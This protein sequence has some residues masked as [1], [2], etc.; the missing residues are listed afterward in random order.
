[1]LYN[2]EFPVIDSSIENLKKNSSYD[3]LKKYMNRIMMGVERGT[4]RQP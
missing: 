4:R 2:S 3:V 1:M